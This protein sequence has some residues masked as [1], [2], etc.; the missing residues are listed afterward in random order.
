[1]WFIETDKDRLGG[2]NPKDGSVIWF[3]V[4]GDGPQ[5]PHTM[6]ADAQGNLWIALEDSF[7]IARFN[8]KSR[9]WRTYPPP[10][11][12]DFGVTHD[13]AYNSDRHVEAD[14]NGRIWITDMGKNELWALDVE[15]GEIEKFVQPLSPGES[16]FHSLLA[17]IPTRE[18]WKHATRFQITAAHPT[19]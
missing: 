16:H 10:A 8:T 7:H 18:W 13:F 14:A 4:P 19:A 15:T 6:N 3:D 2:L 17:S 1:M 9:Q 11:N 5:G 12:T